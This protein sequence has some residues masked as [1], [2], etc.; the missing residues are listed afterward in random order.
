[1][2]Y[3]IAEVASNEGLPSGRLKNFILSPN[4]ADYKRITNN[5]EVRKTAQE[6]RGCTRPGWRKSEHSEN[7]FLIASK[8]L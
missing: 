7:K 3:T 4:W 6:N 2:Q 8:V 1:M 5:K